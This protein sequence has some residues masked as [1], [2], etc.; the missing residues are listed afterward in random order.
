MKKQRY[1]TNYKGELIDN[2]KDWEYK[3]ITKKTPVQ[4]LNNL[5]DEFEK[6]EQLFK[7]T[8]L[9]G[10]NYNILEKIMKNA[11]NDNINLLTD[12]K[13]MPDGRVKYDGM[14][15]T[16]EET[17]DTMN[18]Q[19]MQLWENSKR[20]EEMT[21]DIDAMQQKINILYTEIMM[22]REHMKKDEWEEYKNRRKEL[23]DK[24]GVEWVMKW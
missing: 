18:L 7:D 11:K 20:L 4:M 8:G 15:H 5:N 16:L 19:R 22:A 1:H 13:I 12:A 21:D 6:I 14:R 2:T 24:V 23:E 9:D 17:V 3:P 10:Y